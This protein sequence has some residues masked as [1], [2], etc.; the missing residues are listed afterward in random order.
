MCS[1]DLTKECPLI[2]IMIMNVVIKKKIQ[3]NILSLEV[4]Q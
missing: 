4:K 2:V 3:V 1:C